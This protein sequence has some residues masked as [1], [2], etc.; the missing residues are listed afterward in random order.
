MVAS[1]ALVFAALRVGLSVRRARVARRPP[2]PGARQR[3]LRLAKPAVVCVGVGLVAGPASAVWLRGWEAFGTLHAW[4]GLAA[5]IGFGALALT[6][7][8]LL[9]A[10]VAAVAG[11]VLLP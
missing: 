8:R 7:H 6:G 10:A 11:F 2:P 3:H 9:L 1:L 5:A 4:L